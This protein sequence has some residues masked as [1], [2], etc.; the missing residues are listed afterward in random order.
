MFGV[1]TMAD[2]RYP[3]TVEIKD[4]EGGIYTATK[5]GPDEPWQL[6][7]PTGGQR[8]HGAM[9]QAKAILKGVVKDREQELD[10]DGK[11]WEVQM[12]FGSNWENVWT[13]TDADNK[14]IPLTFATKELAEL[15][16]KD[17]FETLKAEGMDW[18]AEEFRVRPVTE[19][20]A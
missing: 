14:A 12:L 15:E 6:D 7:Y 2:S 4:S 8:F 20:K 16:L 11:R 10:A 19:E 13:E 9:A 18:D 3:V 17:H 1:Q 5:D